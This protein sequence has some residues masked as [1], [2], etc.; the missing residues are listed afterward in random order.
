MLL[1]FTGDRMWRLRD[2]GE[3]NGESRVRSVS[4]L[5]VLIFAAIIMEGEVEAE[6]KSLE[7]ILILFIFYK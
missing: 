1:V 6:S 3:H 7:N 4:P 2:D 5:E